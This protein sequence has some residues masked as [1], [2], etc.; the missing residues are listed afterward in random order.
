MEEN[1]KKMVSYA[2]IY[3]FLVK[4]IQDGV[5]T[6]EYA[7]KVNKKCAADLGCRAFLLN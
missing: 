6:T 3:E 5:M 2:V 7:E 4:M 1:A